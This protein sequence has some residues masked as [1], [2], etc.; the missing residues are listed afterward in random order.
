MTLRPEYSLGHSEY[1]AFLFASV[2]EEK[3]GLQLTVLTAL[4]RLGFDA[5]DEAARLSGLAKD[6][7]ARELATA[8]GR[9]PEGDWKVSEAGAIA[10]RLVTSLPRHSVTAVPPTRVR[11]AATPGTTGGSRVTKWLVWSVVAVATLLLGFALQPNTNLEPVLVRA[12]PTQ[13]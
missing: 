11:Q 8:I 7:A 13:Q 4:T 3:S 1:N 2:G 10:A 5:W 9:L 12:A 6:A